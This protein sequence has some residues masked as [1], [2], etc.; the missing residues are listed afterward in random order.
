MNPHWYCYSTCIVLL[1]FLSNFWNKVG[2]SLCTIK[3]IMWVLFSCLSFVSCH[4]FLS[5][6]LQ[7]ILTDQCALASKMKPSMYSNCTT[8]H[9][10]C[11]LLWRC[12]ESHTRRI[13]QRHYILLLQSSTAVQSPSTIHS[14]CLTDKRTIFTRWTTKCLI[15]RTIIITR[16]CLLFFNWYGPSRKQYMINSRWQPQK[17]SL[18]KRSNWDDY[19]ATFFYIT[20]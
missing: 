13:L 14:T 11:F 1:L 9:N 3:H 8:W 18:L 17:F 19:E 4:I 10:T 15:T 6:F 16:T 7:H 2:V 5:I 20:E 12:I